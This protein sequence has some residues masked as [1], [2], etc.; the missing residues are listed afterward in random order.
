MASRF[1]SPT[2]EGNPDPEK[3]V[4]RWMSD[5]WIK[6]TGLINY[7]I[8]L[9]IERFGSHSEKMLEIPGMPASANRE[10][11]RRATRDVQIRDIPGYAFSIRETGVFPPQVLYWI[12]LLREL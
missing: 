12:P 4:S 1:R 6:R 8:G 5:V 3:L 10:I 11:S 7:A 9:Q 2:L